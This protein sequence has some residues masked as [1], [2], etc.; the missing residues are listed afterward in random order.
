MWVL[1]EDFS[2]R[3]VLG[4]QLI[5]TGAIPP[6]DQKHTKPPLYDKKLNLQ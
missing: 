3:L 1:L 4:N 6:N 5:T 2:A